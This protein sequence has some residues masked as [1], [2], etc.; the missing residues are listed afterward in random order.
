VAVDFRLRIPDFLVR[1]VFRQAFDVF[2]E[3]RFAAGE[4]DFFDAEGN[5][6]LA[7]FDDLLE[8]ENL[9]LARQRRLAVRQTIKT[10]KITAVG[11]ADAQISNLSAVRIGEHDLILDFQKAF[12][13]CPPLFV[14]RDG[15]ARD[16]RNYR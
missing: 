11:Q 15:Q 5:E 8:S 7:D 2:S 6:N 16:R 3:Q 13:S 14:F 9:I 10:A 4:T 1:R 12:V